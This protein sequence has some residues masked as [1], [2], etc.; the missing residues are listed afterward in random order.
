M[1]FRQ[2][3]LAKLSADQTRAAGDEDMH[4]TSI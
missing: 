1:P 2:Q 3:C 4:M